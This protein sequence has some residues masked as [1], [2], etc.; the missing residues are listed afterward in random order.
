MGDHDG[1]FAV[2]FLSV[3][4]ALSRDGSVD[5]APAQ[6][7][8]HDRNSFERARAAALRVMPAVSKKLP[9]G[10]TTADHERWA[11]Q[12]ASE[13]YTLGPL[14]PLVA[15]RDVIEI[16]IAA[17]DDVSVRRRQRALSV[18]AA[19]VTFLSDLGVKIVVE[20]AFATGV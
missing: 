8:P 4:K 1:I 19:G 13:L 2:I 11:E 3:A 6:T 16:R 14:S 12:L 10:A 20:R 17:K 7:W 9:P 5:G 15:D 18:D